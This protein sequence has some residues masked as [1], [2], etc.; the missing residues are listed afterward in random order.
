MVLYLFDGLYASAIGTRDGN[1]VK[2]MRIPDVSASVFLH[3]CTPAKEI[4]GTR[5]PILERM[6]LVKP[7]KKKSF[8]DI[9]RS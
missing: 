3:T 9:I 5:S 4:A 2:G 7:G 8:A 1:Y 6:I